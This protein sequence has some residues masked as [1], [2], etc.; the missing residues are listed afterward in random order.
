MNA[1]IL[2][3]DDFQ[4]RINNTIPVSQ[5]KVE[6]YD[7]IFYPGGFGLLSDLAKQI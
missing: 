6:S 7:A 5:F 2:A 1:E 4:N 3:D